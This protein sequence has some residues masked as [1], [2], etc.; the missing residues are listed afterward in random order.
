MDSFWEIYCRKRIEKITVRE[1]AEKAG[2]NRSTFYEYFKDIYDVLEQMEEELLP[3]LK[4]IPP[5]LNP[6]AA[7][8][9]PV[10][11]FFQMYSGSS[12]YYSVLLGDHGD[13]AFAGKIK[14]SIKTKL[15]QN[16]LLEE[17]EKSRQEAEY[18]LEYVLSGMIGI[19]TYWFKNGKKI[20][21]EELIR[22]M[23]DLVGNDGLTKLAL[24]F[25]L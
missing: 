21:E 3:K 23:Y 17:D 24:R 19:L 5:L 15:L 10:Y 13:P 6:N 20:S 2:Y 25:K 9:V 14:D 18:A 11:S 1:I 22:F 16:L 7:E 8:Q 4:D 12:D